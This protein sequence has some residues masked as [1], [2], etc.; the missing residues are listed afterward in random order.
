MPIIYNQAKN[1][2]CKVLRVLMDGGSSYDII[3]W[4][5]FKIIGVD[6]SLIRLTHCP[7]LAFNNSEVKLTWT[8]TLT[9]YTAKRVVMIIFMAVNTLSLMNVIMERHWINALKGVVSILHHVM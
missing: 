2:R 8:I 1:C 5:A 9:V 4:E 7:L 3:F 6:E